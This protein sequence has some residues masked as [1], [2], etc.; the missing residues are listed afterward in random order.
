M[1]SK[2]EL[3]QVA[4][5]AE[6]RV[7]KAGDRSPLHFVIQQPLAIL[8]KIGPRDDYRYGAGVITLGLAAYLLAAV[9]HPYVGGIYN[10]W[11]M[12]LPLICFAGLLVL[13]GAYALPATNRRWLACKLLIAAAVLHWM[14]VL[15]FWLHRDIF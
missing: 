10:W 9:L 5:A 7:D 12:R 13:F 8:R 1:T 3:A 15:P 6:H 14:F 4:D 2:Q 11:Q